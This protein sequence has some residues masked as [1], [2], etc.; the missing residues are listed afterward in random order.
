MCAVCPANFP[1]HTADFPTHIFF[2][3]NVIPSSSGEC[4]SW[5]A[6]I[7]P[8]VLTS[9][10]IFS[11][12]NE[13][14][15]IYSDLKYCQCCFNFDIY[16]LPHALFGSVTAHMRASAVQL[17]RSVGW[18]SREAPVVTWGTEMSKQQ[19]LM[20]YVTFPCPPWDKTAVSSE[21][22]SAHNCCQTLLH[23]FG[24]ERASE[25]SPF[26]IEKQKVQ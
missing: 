4:S 23:T 17:M 8:S 10:N 11:L 7:W 14:T 19:A 26:Q 18:F 5:L 16:L 22:V 6:A 21:R 13:S 15:Q 20:F 2:V 9:F 25:K 12:M 24:Y 3:R 1:H